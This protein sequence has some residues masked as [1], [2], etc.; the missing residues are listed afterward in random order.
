MRAS[1]VAVVFTAMAAVALTLVTTAQAATSS[2]RPARVRV[3]NIQ[4]ALSGARQL[5]A[6]R[7][8]RAVAVRLYLPGCH[9]AGLAR[10]VKAVSTP[11]SAPYRQYLTPAQVRDR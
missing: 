10:A 1:R 9:P 2:P 6:R 7:P 4:P 8:P 5:G 3:P 11:G